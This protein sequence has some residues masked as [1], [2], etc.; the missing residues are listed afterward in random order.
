MRSSRVHPQLSSY[1]HIYGNLDFNQ[2]PLAPP[3]CKAIIFD[4][5]TIR[6]TWSPH[7][8]LAWCVGPAM[9]H[10]RCFTF[11]VPSTA[12]TRIT[13]TAKTFPT[14]NKM[15]ELTHEVAATHAANE[16]IA[17]LNNIIQKNQQ[18]VST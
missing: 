5:P 8:T 13:A 18:R 2:T 12:A 11:Y 9:N 16:L 14:K 10:Y 1:A 4:D 17:A 7:G 3:G 15:P 6:G